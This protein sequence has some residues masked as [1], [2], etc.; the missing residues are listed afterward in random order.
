[1]VPAGHQI[2]RRTVVATPATATTSA[3]EQ[4]LMDKLPG[5][6]LP[7]RTTPQVAAL[8]GMAPMGFVA[9]AREALA[10]GNGN[11][12]LPAPAPKA[13]A[14]PA[15]AASTEELPAPHRALLVHL[16]HAKA[17]KVPLAQRADVP[18]LWKEAAYESAKPHGLDTHRLPGLSSALSKR[19]LIAYEGKKHVKVTRAGLTAVM[20]G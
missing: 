18:V 1:V 10:T 13:A 11:I 14:K 19:G 4:R 17:F 12:D 5:E 16:A 6:A 15:A 9:L 7:A 3:A 20:E 2:V 8:P